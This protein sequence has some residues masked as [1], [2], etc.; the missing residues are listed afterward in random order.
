MKGA[1][2][3]PRVTWEN[4][5]GDVAESAWYYGGVSYV[6]SHD[7]MG[8]TSSTAFDPGGSMDRAMVWAAIARMAGET[9][10]GGNWAEDAGAWAA[11]QGISDGADPDG[12]VTRGELVT[13]L[14]RYVGSPEMDAEIMG[15]IGNY[16]D[17]DSVGT[18]A[19][20]AFA[21]ALY[22]GIITGR[23]GRLAAGDSVTRAEA[24]TILA[25]FC[26]MTQ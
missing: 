18:W 19:Q 16:P 25:R 15:R 3:D 11:A 24:A 4:P 5:Y 6:A 2:S 1:S 22:Q 8:G 23:D 20:S 17:G 26:L 21:W 14:Y 12:T 10:S 13:M 7:F 9:I